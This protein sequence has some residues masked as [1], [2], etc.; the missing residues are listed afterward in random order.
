MKLISEFCL[1]GSPSTVTAQQKGL[2]IVRGHAQFYE[3]KAVTMAKDD[4]KAEML[5]YV[6]DEPMKGDIYVRV[7]W[8]FCKATL[9]KKEAYTF[10]RSRPD[11]DNMAKGLFDCMTD[12]GFWDDDSQIVKTDLTKAWNLSIPGLY[13]QIYE[14]DD[15]DDY[16]RIVHGWRCSY[17]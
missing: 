16:E 9:T 10:K 12:L 13:I 5:P 6:P 14:L 4:L 11:L 17:G 1:R 8:A 2:R 3:K 15:P 7:L